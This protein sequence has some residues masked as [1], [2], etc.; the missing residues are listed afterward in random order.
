[1]KFSLITFHRC[2]I[3][4]DFYL[5]VWLQTLRGTKL[6]KISY[7]PPKGIVRLRKLPFGEILEIFHFSKEFLVCFGG[8]LCLE[9]VIWMSTC[10]KYVI[11]SYLTLSNIDWFL[12]LIQQACPKKNTS[13]LTLGGCTQLCPLRKQQMER[14]LIGWS[15]K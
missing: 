10:K 3:I 7:F 4:Q 5:K 9:I 8:K 2:Y 6:S 11:F 15:L 12:F 14:N 13:P 1:M